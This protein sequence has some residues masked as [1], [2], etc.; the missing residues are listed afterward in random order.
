VRPVISRRPSVVTCAYA[1]DAG[2]LMIEICSDD[3]ISRNKAYEMAIS[4][5][6]LKILFFLFHCI[7]SF[8]L[9]NYGSFFVAIFTDL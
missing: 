7:M 1:P 8:I 4:V 5:Q 9:W 2:H 3:F 6:L